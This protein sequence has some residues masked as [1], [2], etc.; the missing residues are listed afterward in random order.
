MKVYSEHCTQN[1]VYNNTTQYK[2][3]NLIAILQSTIFEMVKFE[4]NVFCVNLPLTH[5][6]NNG[7]KFTFKS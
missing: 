4:V 2:Q 1:I 6:I 7:Y 3:A 5:N